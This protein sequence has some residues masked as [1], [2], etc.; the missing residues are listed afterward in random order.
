M[1][2]KN[3]SS[4][5][6][7]SAPHCYYWLLLLPFLLLLLLLV[8]QATLASSHQPHFHASRCA[9]SPAAIFLSVTHFLCASTTT[10][11]WTKGQQS[12]VPYF[13]IFPSIATACF[14]IAFLCFFFLVYLCVCWWWLGYN[15]AARSLTCFQSVR[16]EDEDDASYNGKQTHQSHK[17]VM[18]EVNENM[19]CRVIESN[20]VNLIFNV[21]SSNSVNVFALLHHGQGEC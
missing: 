11:T 16:D 5:P 18:I 3:I 17:H 8:A 6:K 14:P 2:G 10:G 4:A 15:L 7:N 20:I 19:L 1:N 9:D 12:L 13:C 21:D